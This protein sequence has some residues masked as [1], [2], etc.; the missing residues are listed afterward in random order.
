M[1]RWYLFYYEQVINRQ[2]VVDDFGQ[3]LADELE[4]PAIFGLVPWGQHIDIMTKC[5]KIE[6][7]L[8]YV[9]QVVDNNWSR[10]ELGAKIS[11]DLY[12][13]QG[14]A[15]TNF[16]NTLPQEQGNLAKEILKDPYNFGFLDIAEEHSEKE[17]EEA[18]EKNITQFL[19]ELG[20][21][22][23]YVGRQMELRMLSG[24]AFFPDLIFYHTLRIINF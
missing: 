7:A 10:P 4:M 9:H 17:L 19:L 3:Q 1:K 6:E 16:D 5:E 20:K 2:R 24:K 18:L 12:K 22:F 13:S 14:G 11:A 23:A 15:V 21:G 8:F